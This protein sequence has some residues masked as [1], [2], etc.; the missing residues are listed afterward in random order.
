MLFSHSDIRLSLLRLN[1]SIYRRVH[2]VT[3]NTPSALTTLLSLAW[4]TVMSHASIRNGTVTSYESMVKSVKLGGG[5][6]GEVFVLDNLTSTRPPNPPSR[7]V[8]G[9]VVTKTVPASPKDLFESNNP[10]L[11]EVKLTNLAF[12]LCAVRTS[13]SSSLRS[14][15]PS[16]TLTLALRRALQKA[17]FHRHLLLYSRLRARGRCR[18]P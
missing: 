5:T 18:N 16:L 17:Q 15:A 1:R 9:Q 11:A 6:Y 14:L 7:L 13:L 4:A 8:G 2:Y 12:Q 3:F 10:A